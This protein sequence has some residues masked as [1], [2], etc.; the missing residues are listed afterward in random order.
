MTDA[1]DLDQPACF[2]SCGTYRWSLSRHLSMLSSRPLVSC[3]YNPSVAGVEQNDPTIRREIDFGKRWDCG[4]LIKINL[5]AAVSTDPGGLAALD[6]PVGPLNDE[7]IRLA[8]ELC[9][10]E[11]GILLAC[12]GVPKGKAVT[13]RLAEQRHAQVLALGPW[14][15]M[16]ITN[17]G[18]PEH[19]LYLPRDLTPAPYRSLADRLADV[20]T[21][22]P[23]P[24]EH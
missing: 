1:I 9:E 15:C 7:A 19:P 6:D 16:R 12:W 23:Q 21:T 4:R 24:V 5:F 2:S 11:G 14:Q 20:R 13:R 10:R 17:H 18:Y 22:N 3:G 8:I